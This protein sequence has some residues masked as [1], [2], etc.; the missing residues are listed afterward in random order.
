MRSGA[1]LVGAGADALVAARAFRQ[2]QHE[3]AAALVEALVDVLADDRVVV[4]VAAEAVE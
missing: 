3:Q 1:V 4:A 2:V